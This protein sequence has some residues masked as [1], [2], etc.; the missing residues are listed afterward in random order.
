MKRLVIIFFLFSF[1]SCIS[2]SNIDS[3]YLGV[4]KNI[5][6]NLLKPICGTLVVDTGTVSGYLLS[7]AQESTI[8]Y[9][10]ATHNTKIYFTAGRDSLATTAYVERLWLT[11]TSDFI[12]Y[13]TPIPVLG[14]GLNG[15]TPANRRINSSF[16]CKIGNTYYCL[17]LNGYSTIGFEGNV[18]GY[19]STD[20]I[21]WVDHGIKINKS[22]AWS[23]ALSGFGNTGVCT[24]EF[25]KPVV[26]GGKYQAFEDVWNGSAWVIFRAT[27]DSLMGNWTLTDS[28]ATLN[29]SGIPLGGGCA[30]YKN[31]KY[32]AFSFTNILPSKLGFA[33]SS[34][35]INWTVKEF[36]YLDNSC[37]P[38]T[39]GPTAQIADEFLS[40]INGKVYQTAE[41]TNGNPPY[42]SQIRI[43]TYSATFQDMLE[44]L[45]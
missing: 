29:T 3:G 42:P 31:G 9:D 5:L 1:S 12:S 35:F 44:Q 28:L 41:Y 45:F 10:S 23:Y 20:G 30:I 27:A 24:D 21:N 26:I 6:H 13:S 19:T 4:S 25:N 7:W 2:Q 40:Q 39:T 32:Y 15:T 43:W 14:M 37:N 33:Y 16:V 22:T 36:P 8:F 11:T 18:Y 17:A 34:D 38:Y